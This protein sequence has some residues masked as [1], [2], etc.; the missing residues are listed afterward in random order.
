MT[1]KRVERHGRKVLGGNR[2][3]VRFQDSD[4]ISFIERVNNDSPSEKCDI[5]YLQ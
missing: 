2:P 1:Y 4:I 5:G 3:F